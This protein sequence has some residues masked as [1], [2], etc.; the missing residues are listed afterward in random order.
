MNTS[1]HSSTS[2]VFFVEKKHVRDIFLFPHHMGS[3]IMSLRDDLVHAAVFLYV[4]TMAWL[5]ASGIFN[6]CIIN[7]ACVL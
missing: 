3:Q 7:G 1:L 6:M 4:Q 5:A 2:A